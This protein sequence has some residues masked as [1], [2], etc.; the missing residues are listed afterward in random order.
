MSKTRRKT[1]PSPRLREEISPIKFTEKHSPQINQISKKRGGARTNGREGWGRTYTPRGPEKKAIDTPQPTGVCGHLKRAK[2]GQNSSKKTCRALEK[3]AA[4]RV[5]SGGRGS[6]GSSNASI[7]RK[8]ARLAKRKKIAPG[9]RA[10]TIKILHVLGG[11]EGGRTSRAR[12]AGKT[13]RW[14]AALEETNKVG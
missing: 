4:L 9:R 3:N 12:G 10:N 14:R 2:G 8:R 13:H 5:L 11:S 1:L 6:G 7:H